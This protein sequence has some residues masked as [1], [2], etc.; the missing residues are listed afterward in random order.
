MASELEASSR[1]GEVTGVVREGSAETLTRTRF[2]RKRWCRMRA[3]NAIERPNRGIRRRTRAAGAFPDGR[4]APMPAAARLKHVAESGW[5][6]RR[7]LGVTL[8]DE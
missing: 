3:D 5:G 7:Y 2:P 4:S 6:S 8:L 1:L